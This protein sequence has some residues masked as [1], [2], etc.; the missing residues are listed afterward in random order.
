MKA[1]IL[2]DIHG[3][4]EAL[5]A[6]FEESKGEFEEIWCLGDIVG[7]GPSPNQCIE[8]LKNKENF[9]CV[10]G[11][12]DAAACGLLD[13]QPFNKDA[14]KSMDWTRSILKKEHIQFL[15]NLPEIIIKDQF[16]LVHG[17]PRAP[18]YEYILDSY[19][20]T[21]NFKEITTDYCIIGH[22]HIPSYFHLPEGAFQANLTIPKPSIV[23]LKPKIIFNPG[24]VGQPRD[25]NPLPS[26]VI[27]DTQALTIEY[28]RASYNIEATQKKMLVQNL[29]DKHISRLKLGI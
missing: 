24:S 19:I 3:N 26:Y 17:S 9:I 4:F 11:N 20:A 8:F 28:R 2:S 22:S 7:Y 13:A 12:H 6:V 5:K 23:H 15:E 27:L 16:T 14:R 1:L 29:P 10:L 25:R 21:I 18:V